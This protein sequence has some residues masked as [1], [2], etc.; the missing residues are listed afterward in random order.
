MDVKNMSGL[1]YVYGIR[2]VT[3]DQYAIV[4]AEDREESI[5]LATDVQR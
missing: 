2:K 4:I 1:F 3:L 5:R